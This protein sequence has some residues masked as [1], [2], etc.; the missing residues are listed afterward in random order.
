MRAEPTPESPQ[1][2]ENPSQ[3][4][5]PLERRR[6]QNRLSQRNHRR[7]IR[8]R[9]AKLQE[10]VIANELRAAAALNSWDQTYLPSP[11]VS[12]RHDSRH[13]SHF[14]SPRDPSFL[15]TEP[16]T[17]SMPPYIMPATPPWTNDWPASQHLTSLHGEPPFLI[18]GGI[19]GD[20]TCSGP[21]LA[22]MMH[23]MDLATASG[24]PVRGSY[25]DAL[26]GGSTSTD[27]PPLTTTN[28]PLYY[29][30]T[31]TALPQIL[32]VLN[33]VSPQSSI[34]VLVPDS[35]ASTTATRMPTP[36]LL[37]NNTMD[38]VSPAQINTP[39]QACQFQAQSIP[40]TTAT[41]VGPDAWQ[42]AGPY[43]V[44]LQAQKQP[45]SGGNFASMGL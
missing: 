10:R 37:G 32:Q 15:T 34:I 45:M 38:P 24:G 27:Y 35:A 44:G 33:T 17:P 40:A 28:Q 8:D 7:K 31:E 39:G 41:Q 18:D 1:S 42:T 25:Y 26:P 43:M 5:D 22:H 4:Q 30:A 11:M 12:S 29:I 13:E 16:S 2:D 20:T 19:M 3:K 14:V 36:G 21:A 23:N 9:I 6:L